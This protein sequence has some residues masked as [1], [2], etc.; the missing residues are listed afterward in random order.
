MWPL[1][2]AGQDAARHAALVGSQN[3]RLARQA[4]G[5]FDQALFT[6]FGDVPGEYSRAYLP[7]ILRTS[8]G[9]K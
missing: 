3:G 9:E 7:R 8:E 4:A 6:V 1:S 2:F 5:V